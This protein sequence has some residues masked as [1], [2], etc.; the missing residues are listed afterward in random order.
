VSYIQQHPQK[1]ETR[2]QKHTGSYE[3]KA[4]TPLEAENPWLLQPPE[5]WRWAG[6]KFLLEASGMSQTLETLRTLI[7]LLD[8]TWV[9]GH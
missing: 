5:A 6:S 8:A 9:V 1:K 4:E 7:L 3:K 2:T